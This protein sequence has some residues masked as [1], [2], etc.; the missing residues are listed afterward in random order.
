VRTVSF[1]HDDLLLRGA[2]YLPPGAG[3]HPAVV[4]LPGHGLRT[5]PLDPAASFDYLLPLIGEHLLARGVAVLQYGRPGTAGSQGDWRHQTLYDRADEALAA[6]ALLAAAPE[7]RPDQIGLLGHSNGG[8][9]APLAATLSD[10]VRFI[11]TVAGPGVSIGAQGLEAFSAALRRQGL[12]AEE[13]A[14][15]MGLARSILTLYRLIVRGRRTEFRRLKATLLAELAPYEG[16]I[17]EFSFAVPRWE[18]RGDIL[19]SMDG[20]LD[21]DAAAVL[22]QVRCPALAIFGEEDSAFDSRAS[23]AIFAQAFREGG[24]P[25]GSVAILPGASHRMQ[26]RQADGSQQIAPGFQALVSGW[27]AGQLAA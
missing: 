4:L 5:S 22:R 11:V 27:I 3:P 10:Q 24:N 1:H 21:H 13:Q 23:A 18:E 14:R 2:L 16:R 26:V 17:A 12:P 8:W 25:Q 15:L 9:V 20:L 6:L 19:R 7:L